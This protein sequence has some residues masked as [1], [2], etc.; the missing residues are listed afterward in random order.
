MDVDKPSTF[1]V[2]RRTQTHVRSDPLYPKTSR[3]AGE[4]EFASADRSVLRVLLKVK[5]GMGEGYDWVECGACG[6]GWQVPHY[7][8]VGDDVPDACE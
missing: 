3:H 2:P 7:E 8:R 4:C 1:T 6:V 5:P